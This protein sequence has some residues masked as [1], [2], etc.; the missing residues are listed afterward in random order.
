MTVQLSPSNPSSLTSGFL[1]ID[2]PPPPPSPQRVPSVPD[3]LSFS[4]GK[5]AS[6][7][8]KPTREEFIARVEE[9]LI[10]PKEENI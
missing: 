7:Y 6:K 5:R 9:V 3:S 10:L 8:W 4:A 2:A 1:P